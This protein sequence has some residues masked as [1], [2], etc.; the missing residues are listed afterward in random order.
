MLYIFLFFVCLSGISIRIESFTI[1]RCFNRQNL[2]PTFKRSLELPTMRQTSSSSSSYIIHF[3]SSNG[4]S[5]KNPSAALSAGVMAIFAILCNR[6]A[7]DLDQVTDV[8]SRA[9]ILSVIACSAVLLNALSESAI[10]ARERD[11]VGLVGYSLRKPIISMNKN[12]HSI[13]E[14]SLLGTKLEWL[15]SNLIDSTPVTSLHI[16]KQ[17]GCVLCRAGIIGERDDFNSNLPLDMKAMPILSK[18]LITNDVIYLPDL[19]I[20][21]GKVEFLYLPV[22][23]QSVLLLPFADE[24]GITTNMAVM[25]TNQAKSLRLTDLEKIRSSFRTFLNNAC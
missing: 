8:Q 5:L 18:C 9:D 17:N 16:I 14:D 15:C 2:S 1:K 12:E 13:L 25:G 22:N 11:P 21:P 24:D 3:S 10:E 20:L 19:Q 23:C 4:L 7:I 6:L